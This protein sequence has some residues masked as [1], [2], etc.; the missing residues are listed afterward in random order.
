MTSPLYGGRLG[1]NRGQMPNMQQLVK[2]NCRY[3][4]DAK[5]KHTDTSLNTVQR[6]IQVQAKKTSCKK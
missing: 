4:D 1:A 6:Q 2:K 5:S 3:V